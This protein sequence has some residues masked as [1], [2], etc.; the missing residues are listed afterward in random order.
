MTIEQLYTGCLAEAAYYIESN[1]EVAIIDPIRD[2]EVYLKKAQESG[3]SI[4]YIFETHFHA[5]F[6][7]GHVEL[8]QKTGATIVYGPNANPSFD[9][10]QAKDGEE[11]SVG[12]IRLRA[13]HTPGHTMESTTYLLL[14]EAGKEHCIFSGDTLFI[15]DVGRPDLAVKSDMTQADLAGHLYDSLRGKIMTLPDEVIVYP[16]HGA[17]SACG[18]NMSK[19]R[20][21]TLGNQKKFNYALREDMTREDFIVEVT[22]GL[23]APPQYFPKNVSL[24]QTGYET[25]AEVIERGTKALSVAEFAEMMKEENTLVLDTRK[26]G[27]FAH[28]HIPGALFIGVD[29]GFAPWVGTVIED[30]NTRILIICDEGRQEEVVTRLSRVGYDNSCGYLKGGMEAWFA[31]GK[32]VDT[33]DEVEPDDLAENYAHWVGSTVDVRKPGEYADSHI[34]DVPSKPLDFIHKNKIEYNSDE[35]Y[36][37][38]CAGGYRSMIAASIL[39]QNGVHDVVNVKGGFGA[40]KQTGLPLVNARMAEASIS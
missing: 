13:L 3:A 8:A 32:E 22:S 25:L 23:S 30:L 15:G 14:D 12:N 4:K 18:K 20:F 37:L 31:A 19:E 17:G 34:L 1:G 33:V 7:S 6:V 9:F 24:N 11:F 27:D 38:H 28:S 5:D 36:Y 35:K 29:G 10:H 21:D 2:I 39:K 40:L 26:P 16:A